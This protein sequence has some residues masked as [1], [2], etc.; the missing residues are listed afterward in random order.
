MTECCP[1]L[2]CPT[3]IPVRKTG[4]RLAAV[5]EADW[6][7][8]E[9]PPQAAKEKLSDLYEVSPPKLEI[10]Y[11]S[12]NSAETEDKVTYQRETNYGN[13][14]LQRSHSSS[15]WKN[16]YR[17][18]GSGPEGRERARPV[19]VNRALSLPGGQQDNK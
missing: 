9:M 6:S 18:K 14:V 11:L 13:V 4:R 1:L 3:D 19:R 10:E 15:W 16:N 5:P 17:R 12:E 7:H 2:S 8:P